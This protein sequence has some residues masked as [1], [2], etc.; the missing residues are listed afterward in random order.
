MPST[1][2]FLHSE[3]RITDLSWSC[4]ALNFKLAIHFNASVTFSIARTGK[5]IMYMLGPLLWRRSQELNPWSKKK[6]SKWMTLDITLMRRNQVSNQG[7]N[8]GK[9]MIICTCVSI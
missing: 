8:K 6:K 4:K 3:N 2:C 1:H 7:V 9:L 5:F